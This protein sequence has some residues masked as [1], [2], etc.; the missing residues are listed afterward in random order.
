MEISIVYFCKSYTLQVTNLVFSNNLYINCRHVQVSNE[1]AID[2]YKRFGFEVV[3]TKKHY[4][5]RIEPADAHVLQK[6]VKKNKSDSSLI[7]SATTTIPLAAGTQNH[8]DSQNPIQV[9]GIDKNNH[10][11]HHHTNN[12]NHGKSKA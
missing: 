3:E 2:F 4:Y 8:E 6:T 1:G 7:T 9:N 12:C 5:K 10:N 11:H